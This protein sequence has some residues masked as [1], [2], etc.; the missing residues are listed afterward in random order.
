MILANGGKF[1]GCHLVLGKKST[2]AN[3][4]VWY[5]EGRFDLIEDYIQDETN[6]FLEFASKAQQMLGQRFG[7]ERNES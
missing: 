5:K 7:G 4:P 2:G 1:K 3:I 6:C